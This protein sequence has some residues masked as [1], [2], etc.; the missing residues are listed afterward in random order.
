LS[1]NNERD[2]ELRILGNIYAELELLEGLV[3]RSDLGLHLR[4]ED[5][6]NFSPQYW[7]GPNDFLEESQVSRRNRKNTDI[8]FNNT[9]TYRKNLN[10][11][12]L[13]IMGGMTA[14]EFSLKR[15][16]HSVLIHQPIM[17][18]CGI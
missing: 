8:V 15:C 14:E 3:F 17:K 5:R 18:V 4:N 13:T 12:D 11:H 10:G 2:T 16:M 6:N 9:L 7:I 1:R